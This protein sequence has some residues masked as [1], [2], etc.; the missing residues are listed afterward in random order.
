[1]EFIVDAEWLVCKEQC[2][3]QKA[4]RRLTLGVEPDMDAPDHRSP[5]SELF[6][7]WRRR[8]PTPLAALSAHTARWSGEGGGARLNLGMPGAT[9]VE[10]FPGPEAPVSLRHQVR[11]RDGDGMRVDFWQEVRPGE[12]AAPLRVSGI[13][14]VTRGTETRDYLVELSH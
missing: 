11:D 14:R 12:A 9:Q 2:V 13:L 8:L 3:L 7:Q 1:V 10:F 5:Q 4:R 6:G